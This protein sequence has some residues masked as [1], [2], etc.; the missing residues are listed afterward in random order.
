MIPKIIHF[1]WLSN[2]PFPENIQECINSWKKYMPEY[3]IKRWSTENFDINS[4]RLVKEAYEQKKYAFAADYIRA[5]ALYHEGGIYLDSDVM[6]YKSFTPLLSGKYISA[7]EF[8][9]PYQAEYRKSITKDFRRK[10]NAK[11]VN[12]VGLQAAFMASESGHPL[13]KAILNE[14]DGKGL[15]D[16]MGK[17]FVAPFVQAR[18]AEEYGFLYINKEQHLKEG[19][20]L[21]PTTIVGQ[22]NRETDGRYLTHMC[23][24]SW[25]KVDFKY[26]LRRW[27]KRHY[28]NWFF[29]KDN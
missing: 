15:N 2:D 20:T 24:G 23:A 3:Q 4:V 5:Y 17:G 7:I 11:Y 18:C 6:I 12:G 27:L 1:C 8:H 29:K 19:I 22:D 13:I 26:R 28:Y 25:V 21:Y 14:Y 16:I 10:D 9:P